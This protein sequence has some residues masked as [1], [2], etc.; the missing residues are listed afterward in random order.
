MAKALLAALV[1]PGKQA[2]GALPA[3]GDPAPRAAQPR[4]AGLRAVAA[5][6]AAAVQ[7]AGE[8]PQAVA[9][10]QARAAQLGVAGF[11]AVEGLQELAVPQASQ[12]SRAVVARKE[13]VV[14]RPKVALAA[15]APVG[16]VARRPAPG[17]PLVPPAAVP[18]V[19]VQEGQPAQAEAPARLWCR[20]RVAVRPRR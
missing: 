14:C 9:V 3:K 18:A 2:Q 10:L 5:L 13:Q 17:G 7:R 1:E 12:V 4:V 8:V 15:A 19:R 11:P 20:A 6:Q 16:Q